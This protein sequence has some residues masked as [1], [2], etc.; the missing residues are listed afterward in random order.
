MDSVKLHAA[1]SLRE[2]ACCNFLQKSSKTGGKTNSNCSIPCSIICS[3]I[4][5]T[6]RKM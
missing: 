5:T 3:A 6:K 2:D 4:T 1:I